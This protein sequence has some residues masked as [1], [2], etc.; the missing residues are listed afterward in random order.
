LFTGKIGIALPQLDSA[1]ITAKLIRRDAMKVNLMT[2]TSLSPNPVSWG[3]YILIFLGANVLCNVA[4]LL[5][6]T[7]LNFEIPSS[8]G[9]IMLMVSVM[10]AVESFVKNES[11][12]LS[13]SERVQFASLGTASYLALSAFFGVIAYMFGAFS[14]QEILNEIPFLFLL[15]LIAIVVVVCWL[16]IYFGTGFMAKQ[17]LKRLEN[18]L[19]KP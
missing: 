2:N 12:V 3:H 4:V 18:S 16:V 7:V 8:M 17:S 6:T 14:L 1:Y 13:K 9:I 15:L 19:K 11:R 10:P 5:I